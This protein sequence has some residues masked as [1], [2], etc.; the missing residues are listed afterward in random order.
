MASGGFYLMHRGWQDHP[1]FRGEAFSR[2]DA[3][4][5]MIEEAA[6]RERRVA[7][8]KGEITLERGQFSH[9]LRY[10]ARA[11]KWEEPRVRRFLTSLQNAEIID[12]TTDAGQTVIK[13]RNYAKYQALADE[14][15]APTDAPATQQRRTTDAKKKELETRERINSDVPDGTSHRA[16]RA[17]RLPADWK[18]AKPYPPN[19]AAMV[20]AWPPGREERELDGFVDY[21]T[22]RSR[23]AA[24]LD[25]DKAWHNRIRDQHDRVMRDGRNGTARNGNGPPRRSNDGFLNALEEAAGWNPHHY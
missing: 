9:S 15:D 20:N 14:A 7:T 10:M 18:P 24:R 4:V 16:K 1:V 5:W 12:A 8:P 25:W 13:L 21:W 19:V 2:R 17:A 6:F 23:D 22:S 11:W 3:F